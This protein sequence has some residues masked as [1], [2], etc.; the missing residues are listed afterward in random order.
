MKIKFCKYKIANYS[1]EK[2]RFLKEKANYISEF[3]IVPI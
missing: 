2:Y 1:I 3:I